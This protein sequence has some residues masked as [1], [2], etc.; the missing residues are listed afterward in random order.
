MGL[1]DLPRMGISMVAALVVQASSDTPVSARLTDLLAVFRSPDFSRSHASPALATALLHAAICFRSDPLVAAACADAAAAIVGV[2]SSSSG[3]AVVPAFRDGSTVALAWCALHIF[4]DAAA[5]SRPPPTSGAPVVC[6][7]LWLQLQHTGAVAAQA[8]ALCSVAHRAEAG[9]PP[10]LITQRLKRVLDALPLHTREDAADDDAECVVPWPVRHHLQWLI[11]L[12][13]E[14]LLQQL[15]SLWISRSSF[16]PLWVLQCAVQSPGDPLR[17]AP[18]PPRAA[19][20]YSRPQLAGVGSLFGFSCCTSNPCRTRRPFA[21]P[22]A[23]C[24]S[25]PWPPLRIPP[26]TATRSISSVSWLKVMA[27]AVAA[28]VVVL[29]LVVLVEAGVRICVPIVTPWQH[30][31]AT[32]APW[33]KVSSAAS[34]SKHEPQNLLPLRRTRQ[35]PPHP[36]PPHSRCLSAAVTC[37]VT[38]VAGALFGMDALGS[39]LFPEPFF[40]SAAQQPLPCALD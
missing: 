6:D 38:A 33:L 25:S 28:A 19:A 39:R 7:A 12:D 23:F 40:G 37:R 3:A 13:S 26:P 30:P 10:L 35:H 4:V 21:A 14:L 36:H 18:P 8:A 11:Q 5:S 34:T 31:D 32:F 16:Q 22:A 27:A 2:C 20:L 17:H 29:V 24:C 15:V 9:S 1:G